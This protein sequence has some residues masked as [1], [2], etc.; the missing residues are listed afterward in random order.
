M[1]KKHSMPEMK[2]GGVN[3]TPLIDVIMCL[4]IFFML[5][6]KIGV[7][8]GAEKLALPE[9]LVGVKIDKL[10][11]NLI[12]NV[13]DPNLKMVNGEVE[14][15]NGRAV[16]EGHLESPRVT[17]TPEVG[18]PLTKEIKLEAKTSSGQTDEPLTRVI[19]AAL[20][21]FPELSVTLRCQKEVDYATL[22]RVI[23]KISK[24]QV[25]KGG[26]KILRVT[27]INFA[28]MDKK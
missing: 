16:R 10:G 17:I 8:T 27:K 28:A 4:I 1:S 6:A 5:V 25:D 12:L 2:E 13:S 15:V 9:T 22:A 3:V 21:N 23:E 14:R 18:N 19:E 26:G 20:K 11:P 24:A 7:A